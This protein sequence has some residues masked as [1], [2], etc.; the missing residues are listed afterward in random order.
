MVALSNDPRRTVIRL[1]NVNSHNNNDNKK[2]D[3]RSNNR[4]NYN[5]DKRGNDSVNKETASGEPS[6][7]TVMQPC[8]R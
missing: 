6:H 4:G 2:N 8:S 3:N 7:L 5:I 1:V